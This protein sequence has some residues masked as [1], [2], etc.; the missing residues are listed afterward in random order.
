ME[1]RFKLIVDL[2]AT[3]WK[4]TSHSWVE[5][6]IIEIGAVLWDTESDDFQ[7]YRTICRPHINR[8]L[9]DFCKS[10][11]GITQ[12]EVDCA[13]HF[14]A[15]YMGLI[16]EMKS[17]I[18]LHNEDVAKY[19]PFE[20][21]AFM[22]WGDWDVKQ[23]MLECARRHIVYPFDIQSAVNIKSKFWDRIRIAKLS[24]KDRGIASAMRSF[25]VEFVGKQHCA[26]YDAINSFMVYRWG[27]A[28][29]DNQKVID[30]T[31]RL[32]TRGTLI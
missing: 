3:C 28:Y 7:F 10:L 23:L 11:T 5:Q 29:R 22:S 19:P 21:F 9:S 24:P 2:E 1:R 13:E 8:Q 32:V 20:R 4:D 14:M 18:R 12:E 25:G 16:K 27:V 15:G 26:L 31:T 17:F 30:A 6:E